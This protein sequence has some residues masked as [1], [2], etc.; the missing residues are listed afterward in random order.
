MVLRPVLRLS[1]DYLVLVTGFVLFHGLF[2]FSRL[3]SGG[4]GYFAFVSRPIVALDFPGV[5]AILLFCSTACFSR[6]VF[7]GFSCFVFISRLACFPGLVFYGVCF[8]LF[9]VFLALFS[10]CF[11]VFRALFSACFHVFRG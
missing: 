9:H 7:C 1:G 2:C 11:R 6:L 10:A 4:S 5:L 3:F 8:G